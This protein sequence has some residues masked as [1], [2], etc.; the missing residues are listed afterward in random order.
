MIEIKKNKYGLISIDVIAVEKLIY[1]DLNKDFKLGC[2]VVKIIDNKIN[3]I[4]KLGSSNY[5]D[6]NSSI[7]K[8]IEK[9]NQM[10]NQK[11]LKGKIKI[12]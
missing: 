12:V 7:D 9:I 4:I 5:E 11:F 1:E 8:E 6:V 10:F 2:N 3:F